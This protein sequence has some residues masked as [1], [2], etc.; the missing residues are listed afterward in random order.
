MDTLIFL[1]V[2]L[3]TWVGSYLTLNRLIYP[4]GPKKW[5]VMEDMMNNG[6]QTSCLLLISGVMAIVV[7]FVAII[8]IVRI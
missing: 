4:N 3:G 8:A 5:E 6:A 7:G 2:V 1:L